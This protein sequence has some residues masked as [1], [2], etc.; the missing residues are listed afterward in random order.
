[1]SRAGAKPARSNLGVEMNQ[2]NSMLGPDI[3]G[4]CIHQQQVFMSKR[5]SDVYTLN[6][7]ASFIYE[8][9]GAGATLAEIE[10]K[11]MAEFDVDDPETVR[12]DIRKLL[13]FLIEKNIVV[14]DR[15]EHILRDIA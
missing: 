5:N 12:Q 6:E 13:D 8:C 2:P 11:V 9:I 1:M 4:R 14:A 15:V 10:S 3:I 7:T